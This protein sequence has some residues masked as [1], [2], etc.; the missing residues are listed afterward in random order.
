MENSKRPPAADQNRRSNIR[1]GQVG[2]AESKASVSTKDNTPFK[3]RP[4]KE[5]ILTVIRSTSRASQRP[6]EVCGLQDWRW[7][8][9]L[10]L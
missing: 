2:W 7:P 6:T 10:E 1:E 9:M 8:F 5:A 4:S 3:E